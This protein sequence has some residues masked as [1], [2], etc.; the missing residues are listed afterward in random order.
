MLGQDSVSTR[1]PQQVFAQVVGQNLG[2]I[3]KSNNVRQI[4][5]VLYQG[6]VHWHVLLE[7]VMETQKIQ[8]LVGRVLQQTEVQVGIGEI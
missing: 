2:H 6:V 5:V 3:V 7:H 1:L 8:G 4:D